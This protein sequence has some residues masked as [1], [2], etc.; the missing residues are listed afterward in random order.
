MLGADNTSTGTAG[1]M[2]GGRESVEER[3][4]VPQ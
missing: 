3:I 4:E 2:D 1:R